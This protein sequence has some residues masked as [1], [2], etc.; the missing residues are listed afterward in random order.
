[1]NILDEN[2][3][4]SQIQV[5][6]NR[7]IKVNQIGHEIGSLGMKDDA[8]IQLLHQ[9]RYATFFTRDLGFYGRR[10]CHENYCMVCLSVEQQ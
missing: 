1:M 10:F 3:M 6:R 4:H 8:I 7:R 2:I 9:I 5:L